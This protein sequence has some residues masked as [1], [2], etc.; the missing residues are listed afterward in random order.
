MLQQLELDI[1]PAFQHLYSKLVPWSKSGRSSVRVLQF[2]IEPFCSPPSF[3]FS[4]LCYKYKE[5]D[6]EGGEETVTRF[7]FIIDIII[8][9]L[10]CY[11]ILHCDG[12]ILRLFDLSGFSTNQESNSRKS[13]KLALLEKPYV[14][15]SNLLVNDSHI[16]FFSS[17]SKQKM[18]KTNDE[19]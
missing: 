14:F 8:L 18:I 10:D 11:Y 19:S 13:R 15:C 2:Q 6:Q 5:K 12:T 7:T 9:F 3:S 4:I 17:F 1:I 16:C